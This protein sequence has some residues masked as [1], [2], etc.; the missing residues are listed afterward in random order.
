M[1]T[2]VAVM[3]RAIEAKVDAEGDRRP[4]R[5]LGATV[6]AQLLVRRP[7]VDNGHINRNT[8]RR[9]RGVGA[10]LVCGL[11]LQLLKDFLRL[12]LGGTHAGQVKRL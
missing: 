10:H 11:E 12:R 8:A 6:K 3:G 1:D 7:L 5:V 9:R 2:K 4:G